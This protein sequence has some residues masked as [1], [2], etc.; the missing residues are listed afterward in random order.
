[1]PCSRSDFPEE[2]KNYYTSDEWF[3]Y[4]NKYGLVFLPLDGRRYG[5][6]VDNVGSGGYYWSSTTRENYTSD[7]WVMS[8]SEATVWYWYDEPKHTGASVRL[9]SDVKY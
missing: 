2:I 3:D 1:M 8:F 9:V 5:T 6:T 4:Y 7:A